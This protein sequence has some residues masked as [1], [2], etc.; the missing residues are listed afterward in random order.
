MMQS[1]ASAAKLRSGGPILPFGVESQGNTSGLRHLEPSSATCHQRPGRN[2]WVSFSGL[3]SLCRPQNDAV[4][5]DALPH[6]TP[7]GDQELARQSHDHGLASAAGALGSG[8]KPLRQSAV[9][10]EHEKSPR[11]LDHAS[12][13][14]SVAGTGQPFLPASSA[15]LVGRAREAGITRYGPSVAHASRQY[16]LHQHVGRLDTNPDHPRQQAHHCVWSN[17]GRLLETLQASVLDL[18]YLITDEP[19]ACHVA[20]QLSQGVGR[21]RLA[22]GGAQAVKTFGGFLQLGI[23]AADA[24]PY[25]RCFHSV[26]D[27]TL[28]SDKALAL[29]VG[30]LGIFVLDCRDRDHPAVIRLASQPT[31]TGAFEQL[32]VETIGLGAPVLARDCYA[33]CVDDVGLDVAR[34]EPTRQPEA[35][36][37]GLEGDRDAFESLSCLLRLFSPAI[38]QLQQGVLVDIELLQRLALDARHNPGNEPA[39]KAHLDHGDQRA[40]RFER[41]EGSAQVVQLL[42]GV[43]LHRFT[44]TSTDAISP[45]TPAP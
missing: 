2:C 7:Q 21:D 4:R 14:P 17:T 35:V 34:P 45:P 13:N 37:A 31:G 11:Q 30:S 39:R 27:P 40:I 26:D 10:L 1:C 33:R 5:Y 24:E 36:T 32:G 28:L 19:P 18:P 38:E 29:T 12:S 20:T 42:H 43:A 41:R 8:S 23:E 44:S 22:L 25:Q 3:R 16:L 15:A 6:E 9:L